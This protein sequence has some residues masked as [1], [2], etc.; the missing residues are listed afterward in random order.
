MFMPLV[1]RGEPHEPSFSCRASRKPTPRATA[2][3]IAAAEAAGTGFGFTG[4][5]AA[6]HHAAHAN[7]TAV[8]MP[9]LMA[10]CA[11]FERSRTTTSPSFSP[12]R[13]SALLADSRPTL[14]GR[15]TSRPGL[16][17]T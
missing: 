4:G 10:Y 8:E 2:A 5:A 3:S 9:G 14:T 15:F 7:I 13:I 11:F 17:R 12:L 16:V 6:A 1:L